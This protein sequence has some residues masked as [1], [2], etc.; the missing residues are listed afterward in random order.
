MIV[1]GKNNKPNSRKF[2]DLQ[3]FHVHLCQGLQKSGHLSI[4]AHEN[5]RSPGGMYTLGATQQIPPEI[6]IQNLKNVKFLCVGEGIVPCD[7]H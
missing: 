7:P 6:A 5:L 1:K 2:W 4:P 3:N